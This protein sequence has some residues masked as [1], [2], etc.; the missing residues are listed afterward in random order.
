MGMRITTG[1]AMNTYRYNLQLSTSNFS[2]AQNTVLTHRKFNSFSDDPSSAIQAWRVRRAMTDVGSYQKNNSDTYT[3]VN[4]AWVTMGKVKNEIADP[5]GRGSAIYG[6]NGP[7]A[8]ARPELGKV[9]SNTAE[10]VIHAMNSAKSGEN[11]VFSGDDEL[12]APFS[13]NSD[14]TVLYYRGVDVNSG[15]VKSPAEDF[16]DWVPCDTVDGKKVP[17]NADAVDQAFKDN[18]PEKGEDAMEQAWIDY[19]QGKS[20][21]K[22]SENPF[23]GDTDDFGVYQKAVDIVNGK[24][25]PANEVERAWAHYN[26]DQGNAQKLKDMSQEEANIDLGMGLLEDADGKLIPGTYFNRAL[27][28]INMLGFGVDKDGDP[29]NICI[30]M[31]Q[32]GEIFSR[33][34][35]TTG[36][37]ANKQDEADAERLLTKLK[38]GVDYVTNQYTDVDTKGSFLQQNESRL[39][40]Q[41]DYLN[42]QRAELEDVD[43]ALAIQNFS[44]S[45]YCYSSALKVGT[46]LLSQSLID[47]MT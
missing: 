17:K 37:Y 43:L 39:K 4:I 38:G 3:R 35:E 13:W 29:Q 20:A 30:M 23:T 16:P 34:N 1:M 25:T 27:P 46:Q 19:Y 10:S 22:P 11:F 9:L 45:Y 42:E 28:G 31:K 24:Q 32:L 40:M 21:V 36:D 2:N 47:Y 14:H 7:T 8:S 5:D 18:L 33:C 41:G 44:W 6:L 26:V 12:N 15:G